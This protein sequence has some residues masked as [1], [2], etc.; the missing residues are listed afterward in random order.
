LDDEWRDQYRHHSRNILV[1]ISEWFNECEPNGND[2][3]H[4]DCHQCGRLNHVDS[5]GHGDGFR[6]SIEDHY[7]FV[8]RRNTRCCVCRLHDNCQ[9]RH[10]AL[11]VFAQHG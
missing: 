7:Y 2:Y 5:A 4:V 11:Y 1:H 9:R 3:L 10:S 6:R 8:P